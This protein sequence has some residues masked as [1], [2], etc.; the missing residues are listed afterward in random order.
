MI[1]QN[2]SSVV[3]NERGYKPTISNV[4]PIQS[5]KKRKAHETMKSDE[6]SDTQAH[7]NSHDQDV[8][9]ER[10]NDFLLSR[11]RCISLIG[12]AGSG[13]TTI[14]KQIL[15]E[16]KSKGWPVLLSAPTH[17]A[18]ARIREA[19]GHHAET[20]HRALGVSLVRDEETGKQYLKAKGS[21]GIQNGSLMI[22][23]ESSMLPDQLLQI[24][25]KLLKRKKCKVIFVGDA[26]QLNPV[27]ENPSKT[28]DKESCEW[29]MIEL[30]KIHRQAAENPII[31]L[32]TEIRTSDPWRIPE[33]KTR[34]NGKS[35]VQVMD[36]K[37]EWADFMIHQ[38]GMDDFEHRYIGYTNQATDEAAKA[39]R[40][41]KYGTDSEMPYLPGEMLVVNT[42]CLPDG[43][44]TNSRKG[45]N[46]KNQEFIH[47]NET[48]IVKNVWNDRGFHYVECDWIGRK[49]V[50]KAFANYRERAD[51]LES[52]KMV[53]IQNSNWSDFFH[54]SDTIADL[55][56]AVS[57]TAHSSQGSTFDNVFI[58]LS[59]MAIC[60]NREERKRLL[61]VAVTRARGCVYVTG[62]LT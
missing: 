32:A 2:S 61:Y 14:L 49:I 5:A 18:A 12:P 37:R 54:A 6:F 48:V 55:R 24:I 52:L 8:A 39:V 11:N 23:D 25:L 56:S 41:N 29:D 9:R 3:R 62:S 40:K 46:R 21:S 36:N 13:K 35:G 33:F 27:K 1:E 20:T 31:A 15:S 43:Q 44:G 47:A 7:T 60:R 19:T 17:Q 16:A 57:V 42:R 50:L 30:T 10:I 45:R 58:N 38:C 53:A 28:V 4:I 59:N 34:K 22:V 26:A 51:Y